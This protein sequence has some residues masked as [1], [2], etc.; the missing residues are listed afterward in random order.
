[1]IK[2]NCI[3]NRKEGYDKIPIK[4]RIKMVGYIEVPDEGETWDVTLADGCLFTCSTQETAQLMS[5]VEELK[6]MLLTEVK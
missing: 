3:E 4:E 5:S 1:M 2:I 6:A